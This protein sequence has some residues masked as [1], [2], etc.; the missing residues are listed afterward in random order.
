MAMFREEKICEVRGEVCVGSSH[1][2]PG[3]IELWRK[4]PVLFSFR[5]I[6]T[7]GASAEVCQSINGFLYV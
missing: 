2:E 5:V 7:T 4:G 6:K 1:Y 3:T